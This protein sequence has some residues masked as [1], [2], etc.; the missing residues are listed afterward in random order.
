MGVVGLGAVIGYYTLVSMTLNLPTSRCPKACVAPLEV[1]GAQHGADAAQAP[2]EP[3]LP[4]LKPAQV[5][6][7]QL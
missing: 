3:S 6:Q 7:T 4:V 2:G 1:L 5:T